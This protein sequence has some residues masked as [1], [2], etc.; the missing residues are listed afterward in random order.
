MADN[1]AAFTIYIDFLAETIRMLAAD[2]SF[3]INQQSF[4]A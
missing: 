3:S 2:T 4:G 1:D